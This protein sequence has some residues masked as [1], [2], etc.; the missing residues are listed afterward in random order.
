MNIRP[1]LVSDA[2][3]IEAI[4]E[5]FVHHTSV[6]FEIDAPSVAEMEHRILKCSETR[7]YFVAEQAELILG[8]A[9]VSQYRIRT[10]YQTLRWLVFIWCQKRMVASW[11][12]LFT[13]P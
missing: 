1:A 4:Y 9:Y 7:R 13:M 10:S 5:P 8:F 6:S 3:A 2:S 11:D 12:G